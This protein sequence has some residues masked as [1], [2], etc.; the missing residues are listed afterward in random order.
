MEIHGSKYV[1]EQKNPNALLEFFRIKIKEIGVRKYTKVLFLS[2]ES[3]EEWN[4]KTPIII[5]N[6]ISFSSKD[7][8][9][10]SSKK[11]IAVARHSYE[12][13]LDRMLQIWRIISV[14]YPDWQLEIYGS[15]NENQELERLTKTLGLNKSL[16]FFEPVKDIAEKYASSSVFVMTSRS[17][18]FPMVL[19]EAMAVGLPCVAYDCPIGPRSII[20]NNESG[21]LIED[22]N[23]DLFIAKLSELIESKELRI[24]MGKSAKEASNRYTLEVVMNQ[25][26]LLLESLSKK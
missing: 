10:A 4:A 19:L 8:S 21:F 15:S 9:D 12:K 24:Q 17:E 6:P 2:N 26:E 18:G 20:E 16:R 22:G 14:K 1:Q 11:V 25:W 5:P 13:G 3:A 7:S 23:Q